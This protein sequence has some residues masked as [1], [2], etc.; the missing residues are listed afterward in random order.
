[1]KKIIGYMIMAVGVFCLVAPQTMMGLKELKFLYKTTFP[2]EVI[3]GMLLLC[4]AYYLIGF[5]VVEPPEIGS[6]KH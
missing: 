4:I 1:M 6:E 5:A 2:G 3:L